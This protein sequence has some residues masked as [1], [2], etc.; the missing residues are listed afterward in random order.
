[1]SV[2]KLFGAAF[3]QWIRCWW[4]WVINDRSVDWYSSSDYGVNWLPPR[5]IMASTYYRVAFLRFVNQ[6]R[7]ASTYIL[8][9]CRIEVLDMVNKTDR[10]C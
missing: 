2:G 6:Q 9:V 1:M 5:V 3:L 4:L 8:T 7:R 10:F